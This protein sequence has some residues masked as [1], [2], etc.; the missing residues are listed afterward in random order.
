MMKNVPESVRRQW[1]FR[2]NNGGISDLQYATSEATNG[3]GGGRAA[4]CSS[5]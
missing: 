1:K 4:L 2:G 3:M 5:Y